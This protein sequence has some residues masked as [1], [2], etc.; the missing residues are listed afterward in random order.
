MVA[1]HPF[2]SP[3]ARVASA[4]SD[5]EPT[6]T[7]P[8]RYTSLITRASRHPIS[9]LTEEQESSSWATPSISIGSGRATTPVTVCDRTRSASATTW[10][11]M[12]PAST[13]IGR[14][15]S[16]RSLSTPTGISPSAATPSAGRCSVRRLPRATISSC[17]SFRSRSTRSRSTSS[18]TRSTPSTRPWRNVSAT[19]SSSVAT[20]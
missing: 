17:A 12:R 2:A 5:W 19:I 7:L 3:W 4:S 20:R 1:P 16:R 14:R 9:P 10:S 6:A 13:R 11:S 15:C 18:T 8:T